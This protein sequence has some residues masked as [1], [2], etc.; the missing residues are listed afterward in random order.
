MRSFVW[1]YDAIPRPFGWRLMDGIILRSGG[2]RRGRC[3]C[4]CRHDGI[5]VAADDKSRQIKYAQKLGDLARLE[6]E[7][8]Y[9]LR[10]A[11]RRSSQLSRVGSSSVSYHLR[12]GPVMRVAANAA[13][14]SS[15]LCLPF[16]KASCRIPVMNRSH[17]APS[18][19]SKIVAPS[20]SDIS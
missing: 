9:R 4:R 19:P 20:D 18:L 17:S 7:A 15:S 10:S 5:R 3:C 13:I 11:R 8:G 12:A 14:H 6:V 16:S 1:Q 2:N